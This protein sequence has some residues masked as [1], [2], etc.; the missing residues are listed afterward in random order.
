MTDFIISR[1]TD[2]AEAQRAGI[3]TV[4]CSITLAGN[5]C[6]VKLHVIA[7]GDIKAAFTGIDTA[8]LLHTVVVAVHFILIDAGIPGSRHRTK[9]KAAARAVAGLF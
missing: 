7:D 6:T 8:L 9:G 2:V 5:H 4:V 1:V 3:Q